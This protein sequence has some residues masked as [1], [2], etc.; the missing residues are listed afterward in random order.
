VIRGPTRIPENRDIQLSVVVEI[1]I[2]KD[3]SQSNLDESV[4]GS[5]TF[6]KSSRS[7]TVSRSEFRTSPPQRTSDWVVA[8]IVVR[9]FSA[10][11]GL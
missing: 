9:S 4:Q 10:S 5:I 6:L 2:G 7:H 1:E 8:L 11:V 3:G